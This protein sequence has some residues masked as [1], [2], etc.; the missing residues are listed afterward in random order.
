MSSSSD[1]EFKRRVEDKFN[2]L[3]FIADTTGGL[4]TMAL[5]DDAVGDIGK[6][7]GDDF[8]YESSFHR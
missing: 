6:D 3:C 2:G 8:A 1:E 4:C 7:I 5:G